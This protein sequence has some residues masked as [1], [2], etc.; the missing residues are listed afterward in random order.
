MQVSAR[1]SQASICASLHIA[2]SF[3][4]ESHCCNL[5]H[6]GYNLVKDPPMSGISAQW[7]L[8]ETGGSLLSVT[9]G[10]IKAVSADNV[11]ALALLACEASGST[12]PLCPSTHHKVEQMASM[13]HQSVLLTFLKSQI[14]YSSGD[15]GAH[16]SLSAP[17]IAMTY[18]L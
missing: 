13:R 8:N 2:P 16:L 18:D 7:S 10:L 1:A 4:F 14:G 11:Q 3:K 5:K 15:A 6:I 9:K 12:L 17:G